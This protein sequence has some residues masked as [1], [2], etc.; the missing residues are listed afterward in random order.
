MKILLDEQLSGLQEYLQSL[1][2]YVTTVHQENMIGAP[3]YKIVTYAKENNLILVTQDNK[4]A[5]IAELQQ[6]KKVW[7]SF[8][9]IAE[10]TH[11]ELQ[12]LVESEKD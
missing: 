4:Q 1:G 3:D 12:K 10:I 6:V 2:Y 9:K 5:Q 11:R 7:I 8:S